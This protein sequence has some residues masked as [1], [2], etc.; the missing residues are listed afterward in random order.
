MPVRTAQQRAKRQA[1]MKAAQQA[2]QHT[3]VMASGTVEVLPPVQ[4]QRDPGGRFAKG[5]T[6]TCTAIGRPR[7]EFAALA[8]HYTDK[9]KLLEIAAKMAAGIDK[10]AKIDN[11]NRLRAIEFII[12]RGYGPNPITVELEIDQ[13]VQIKR[14]I[15]VADTAI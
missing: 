13:Q 11:A 1:A 5:H 7:N 14:I 9:Y 3:P 6:L 12:G 4:Q 10:F 2:Q 15:G 8:R